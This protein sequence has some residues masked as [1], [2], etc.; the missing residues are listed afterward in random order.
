METTDRE[1]LAHD[2]K[3]RDATGYRECAV[4]RL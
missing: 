3:A 1:M 4:S 2:K